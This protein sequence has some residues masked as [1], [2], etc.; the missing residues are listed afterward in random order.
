MPSEPAVDGS[1]PSDA[2]AVLLFNQ[3]PLVKSKHALHIGL[4][5]T[6][7]D[8]SPLR[9]PFEGNLRMGTNQRFFGGQASIQLGEVSVVFQTISIHP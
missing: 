1:N 7:D 5:R 2:P 8:H 3:Q 6:L 9:E 4:W